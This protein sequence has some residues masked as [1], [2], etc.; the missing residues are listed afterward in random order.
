MH[1]FMIVRLWPEHHNDVVLL[2]GLCAMLAGHRSACDE[3]WFCT[4]MGFP[5]LDV[6]RRSAERLA[7]AVGRM[8][9]L[10]IEPGLQ[11][12][13][14]LGHADMHHIPSHAIR[15]QTMVGPDGQTAR[16][17]SCPRDP[18]F[19]AYLGEMARAY[20]ACQLSS[21]WIDDDLRMMWHAPVPYGCF[22]PRCVR[23]FAAGH[24]VPAEREAI[25]S[26]LNDPAGGVTRLAW[27]AFGQS[28]LALVAG[29]IAAAVHEVAP[30]TRMGL[31]HANC[32]RG[33]YHGGTLSA[34]FEAMGAAAPNPVGS[35]PGGGFYADHAPREML[36]K[37]FEVAR[38]VERTPAIVKNICPE[39]ENFTHTAMGKTAHGTAVESTIYLAAGCNS[40]SYAVLCAGHEFMEH[41]GELLSRLGQWRPFWERYVEDHQGTLPSGIDVGLSRDHIGRALQPG[42]RP[43]AWA[44]INMPH[45]YSLA[46]LGLPLCVDPRGA[47]AT[48]LHATAVDGFSDEELRR[49]LAGGLWVDGEALARLNARGMPT[50]VSAERAPYEE[51]YE[52]FTADPINGQHA[53]HVWKLFTFGDTQTPIYRLAAQHSG[54][55][56]LG[57][58][59]DPDGTERGVATLLTPTPGGGRLAVFGYDGLRAVVS[60]ARRHQILAAA[61]WV[62][63]G[64][65]PVWISSSAQVAVFPRSDSAGRL[66]SAMLLNV[67][68]DFTAPLTVRLRRGRSSQVVWRTPPTGEQ[69]LATR[70]GDGEVSVTVPPIAPWSVGYLRL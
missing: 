46:T 41:Y 33:A 58:Y 57:H 29:I 43:M 18:D 10:G 52:T 69:V 8:R 12:A 63:D 39:V 7:I 45:A 44:D 53:G 19:H 40:L 9:E 59:R 25:V 5:E 22:C 55:R 64:Q 68:I 26:K 35:R 31:Q 23:D 20:A 54:A 60:S 62:S 30:A 50:G 34:V 24:D 6:H 3:V 67:S 14:T 4:E 42:E 56:I 51:A 70:A 61:D 13:N 28:S 37:Y 16:M 11:I 66:V 65:M 15:W 2:D 49:L 38:Q 27:A 36:T 21:V 1:P 48:L 47:C 32:E 17:C